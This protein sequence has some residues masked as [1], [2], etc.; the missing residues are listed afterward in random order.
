MKRHALHDSS[1]KTSKWGSYRGHFDR[2]GYLASNSF[3]EL[4]PRTGGF[5]WSVASERSSFM[6]SVAFFPS[7]PLCDIFVDPCSQ[8]FEE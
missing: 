6:S 2:E 8:R 1:D 5:P 7:S 4:I 3:Q